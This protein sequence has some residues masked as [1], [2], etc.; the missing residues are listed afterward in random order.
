MH[1]KLDGRRNRYAMRL[2]AGYTKL[3]SSARFLRLIGSINGLKE[4]SQIWSDLL[5]LHLRSLG[6]EPTAADPCLFIKHFPGARFILLSV[7]VDDG[8]SAFTV[9][10]DEFSAFCSALS[11]LLDG[12]IKW[13]TA[14]EYLA[15]DLLQ[16]DDCSTITLS[17][18]SYLRSVFTTLHGNAS[19]RAYSTP[20][21]PDVLRLLRSDKSAV[22]S[23][24]DKQEYLRLVGIL[25]YVRK[26]R[27]DIE[28][29]TSLVASRVSAPTALHMECA[30][31]IF[32][33]LKCT[34]SLGRT[35]TGDASLIGLSDS[36]FGNTEDG[37]NYTGNVILLGGSS[38]VSSTKKQSVVTTA[39]AD[40]ELLALSSLV[41]SVDEVLVLLDNL[42]VSVTYPVPVLCD[43]QATVLTAT[44][45]SSRKSRHLAI[46][47]AHVR[48]HS[49]RK[50]SIAVNFV[51]TQ[52]NLADFFTK[53]LPLATFS[54]FRKHLMLG[55]PYRPSL[56]SPAL[57]RK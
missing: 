23:A 10:A 34:I 48:D 1:G 13:G 49:L 27:P 40:A 53:A 12:R 21:A 46:A 56:P 4:A 47:A 41:R 9:T 31:R 42:H 7:H 32:G 14:D 26:A 6:F 54:R 38:I 28:Y 20:A 3:D 17:M 29:A 25:N 45:L 22:L 19:L 11:A 30:L 24:G 39:T 15:M 37:Y 52:D 35:F 18:E 57:T 44:T 5:S 55:E 43:N 8:L 33:Y 36:D 16:S 2:P 51:G 50:R